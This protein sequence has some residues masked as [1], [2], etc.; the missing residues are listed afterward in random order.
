MAKTPTSHHGI[1]KFF[2]EKAKLPTNQN[3]LFCVLK[4][5]FLSF[6]VRKITKK[7]GS[8]CSVLYLCSI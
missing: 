4:A 8:T 5:Y 3:L 6:K 2:T 1:R 7:F